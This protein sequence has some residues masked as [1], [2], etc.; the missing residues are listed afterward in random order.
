MFDTHMSPCRC[1]IRCIH[2]QSMTIAVDMWSQMRCTPRYCI[3]L[4]LNKKMESDNIDMG[5]FRSLPNVYWW[6]LIWHS[7]RIS[8]HAF[9]CW[10]AIR[11]RLST[12]YRLLSWGYKVILYVFYRRCIES[13]DHLFFECKFS[14]RL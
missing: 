1:Q 4:F 14:K 6:R 3:H 9:I 7:N 2:N 11:D 13:R 8:K 12:C 5:V 10:L